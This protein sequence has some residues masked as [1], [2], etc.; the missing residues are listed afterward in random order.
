[1]SIISGALPLNPFERSNVME[2]KKLIEA[3]LVPLIAFALRWFF[4][5]VGFE[6][7]DEILF[8]L[9]GA[10]VA[11]ILAQF[12]GEPAARALRLK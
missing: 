10:I 4:A 8:A 3:V 5:L 12:F 2:W 11:W 6:A 7:S 9:V 1:M